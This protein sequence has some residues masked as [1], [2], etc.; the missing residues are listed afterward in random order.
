MR[1]VRFVGHI[2]S[3]R[4]VNFL[5]TNSLIALWTLVTIVKTVGKKSVCRRVEKK[6]TD[7]GAVPLG[8]SKTIVGRMKLK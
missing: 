3:M 4:S 1:F 2:L 8:A 7:D 5:L 6:S